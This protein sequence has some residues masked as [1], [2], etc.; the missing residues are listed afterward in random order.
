[1]V[2]WGLP[3]AV[4]AS[5][6]NVVSIAAGWGHSLAL[7][8]DG[9]IVAW[10]DN[11]YGQCN[12]PA[13]ATNVVAISAGYYHS[14]ALRSDGTLLAWGAK[15]YS[16]TNAQTG[17]TNISALAAGEDYNLVLTESG[18]PRFS[19]PV[20]PVVVG[21]NGQTLLAPALS[22]VSGLF[23]QWFHGADPISGATN[24][25]LSRR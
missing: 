18:P 17:L 15:Y 23:C 7:R 2:S 11:S 3:N 19:G 1:M 5:A 6:T 22:G 14:L 21:V 4:P 24:R 9:A 20:A 13:S 25:F 8:A 12:V 10:G 16:V